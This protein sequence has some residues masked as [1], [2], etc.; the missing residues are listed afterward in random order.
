MYDVTDA[1]VSAGT[2]TLRLRFKGSHTNAKVLRASSTNPLNWG[3]VN[4]GPA[5]AA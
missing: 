1:D 5:A 4:L 2:V 3:V